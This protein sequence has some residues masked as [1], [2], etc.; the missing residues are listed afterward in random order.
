MNTNTDK[1]KEVE[2]IKRV[3]HILFSTIQWTLFL[4][5]KLVFLVLKSDKHKVPLIFLTVCVIYAYSL[6]C[7]SCYEYLSDAINFKIDVLTSMI[8]DR[9]DP[10]EPGEISQPAQN[11]PDVFSYT[12]VDKNVAIY[13]P[14]ALSPDWSEYTKVSSD[15]LSSLKYDSPVYVTTNGTKF[16]LEGCRHLNG[17]GK[18]LKYQVAL[19]YG[20]EPCKVCFN[21]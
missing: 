15:K 17:G 7:I 5:I 9:V 12:L 14:D 21:N 18:E 6:C 13:H 11:I 19:N 3:E 10:L 16:H 20:Y 2:S 4:P 8:N 1:T